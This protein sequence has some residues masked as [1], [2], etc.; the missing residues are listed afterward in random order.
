MQIIY[1]DRHGLHSTQKLQ[2][3]PY[4]TLEVPER[5][6]SI[7]NA[8]LSACIGTI[9]TPQDHGLAPILAVH[10]QV[11][12]EF[13]RGAYAEHASFNGTP[14]PIYPEVFPSR[15]V[16][17]QPKRPLGVTGFYATD[18]DSPILAGTWEASYWSVQC[19]LTAAD[20]VAAGAPSV[21]ALC[22][23]PGHHAYADMYGG[24]CYLNNAAVAARFLQQAH[25]ASRV[26]ILDIDYHHG[27][28]TQSIFYS[29]PSVLF[30]SLHGN[31]DEAY[32]YYSGMANERGRGE[33][34]DLNRNFPLPRGSDGAIYL[35]A[36]EDAL[37]CVRAFVPD[38]LIVSVGFDISMNDPYGGF[39]ITPDELQEI[40][41]RIATMKLPT[42][43]VQEG[44]YLLKLLGVEA[45]SFLK[46]FL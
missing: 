26:A 3:R 38:F 13:L 20:R 34:I 27:N 15:Y 5:A 11:Y 17:H 33:A 37:A 45:V 10:T 12:A 8:I 44:G 43:L 28:G 35:S 4:D 14:E 42:L 19:A 25:H 7:R 30:C 40:G 24:F 1:N 22:R 2:G 39:R 6:E 9:D 23:P 31:P 29:D 18:A 16:M 36:L 46:A 41:R 21:F 32:P